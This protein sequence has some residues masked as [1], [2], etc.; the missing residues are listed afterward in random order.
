MD[1]RLEERLAG[2][3]GAVLQALLEL[4][5]Q[6]SQFLGVRRGGRSQL[7]GNGQLLTPLPEVAHLR[8]EAFQALA[9]LGFGQRAGLERREVALDGVFGLGDPGVDDE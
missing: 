1:E 3:H 2:R 5:P 6:C 4:T 9:A 7:D 8:G